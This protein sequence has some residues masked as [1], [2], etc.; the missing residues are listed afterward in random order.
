M[1]VMVVVVMMMMMMMRVGDLCDE[2]AD[3]CVE[4][5]AE[6]RNMCKPVSSFNASY[7]RRR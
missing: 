6:L 4:T 7:D 5:V 3:V 1:M 2:R